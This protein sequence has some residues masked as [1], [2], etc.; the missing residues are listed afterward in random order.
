MHCWKEGQWDMRSFKIRYLYL[1]LSTLS[2]WNDTRGQEKEKEKNNCICS[3]GF[4][5]ERASMWHFLV[6][7]MQPAEENQDFSAQ[8][9]TELSKE[10]VPWW[11][12]SSCWGSSC[13]QCA[14][15]SHCKA[16][17]YSTQVLECPPT[18]S[19]RQLQFLL[20]YYCQAK[21]KRILDME[22]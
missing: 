3:S 1:L 22:F 12:V 8:Y 10:R 20:Q 4:Q 5:K 16:F 21:R 11:K 13:R 14:P 18:G 9:I 15:N 7:D 19:Q 6:L 17:Q 2:G